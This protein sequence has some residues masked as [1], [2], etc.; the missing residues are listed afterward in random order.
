MNAKYF[1]LFKDGFPGIG[2]TVHLTGE[3]VLA[4]E[5]PKEEVKTA[6]GLVLY[7]ES[8]RT[9]ALEY[10]QPVELQVLLASDTFFDKERG[11]DRE[12]DV[13]PGDILLVPAV[14][15]RECPRF[16]SLIGSTDA[17][18]RMYWIDFRARYVKFNGSAAYQAMKKEVAKRLEESKVG[19]G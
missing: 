11:E 8:K 5:L 3:Y 18:S 4:Q 16:F 1:D 13:K 6:S 14:A 19:N 12:V 17:G 15:L 2:E 10:G 7:T 9:D